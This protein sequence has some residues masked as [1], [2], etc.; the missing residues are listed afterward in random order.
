MRA[1]LQTALFVL[2]GQ[3]DTLL[4]KLRVL[5]GPTVKLPFQGSASVPFLANTL[6]FAK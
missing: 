1:L 5:A 6:L 3:A 2:F 4:E